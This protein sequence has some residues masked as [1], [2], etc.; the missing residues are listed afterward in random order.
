MTKLPKPNSLDPAEV[1]KLNR[2][3]SWP[4]SVEIKVQTENVGHRFRARNVNQV[5]A[6]NLLQAVLD[7]KANLPTP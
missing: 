3:F 7:A 4:Y 5:D 6:E 1:K 2:L